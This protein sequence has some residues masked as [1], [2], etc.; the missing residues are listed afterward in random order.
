MTNTTP[1]LIFI[2]QH[3]SCCSLMAEGFAKVEGGYLISPASAGLKI[4]DVDPIAVEVMDELG[5]DLQDQVP[6]SLQ[7]FHPE[8]FDVVV[9]MCGCA[10]DLPEGWVT[11]SNFESWALNDPAE[12][13]IDVYRSVRDLI[14]TQVK[15][16]IHK[17]IWDL[18]Y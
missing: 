15:R 16:L 6:L 11:H 5:I 1:S 9:A 17:L 18:D 7:N 12:Q 3:N 14:Q 2:S 8:Q 13:P 10:A 4:S